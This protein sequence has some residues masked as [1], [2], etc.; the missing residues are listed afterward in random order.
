MATT[1]RV[2]D[3]LHSTL[4]E[5]AKAERRSIGQVIEDAVERYQKERFWRGVHEDYARLKLDPE[6]WRDYEDEIKLWDATSS[7]G[8]REEPPYEE[9]DKEG[10]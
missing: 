2:D 5:I 8:L 4:R 9:T 6:A 7:D 3:K 1:V 10:E